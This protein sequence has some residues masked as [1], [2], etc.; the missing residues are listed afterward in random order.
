MTDVF[1]AMQFEQRNTDKAVAKLHENLR[2]DQLRQNYT[3]LDE[4]KLEEEKTSIFETEK[5]Q[6]VEQL[7]TIGNITVAQLELLLAKAGTVCDARVLAVI[8]A[9]L[10]EKRI[11][12]SSLANDAVR[13]LETVDFENPALQDKRLVRRIKVNFPLSIETLRI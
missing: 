10:E 12:I 6:V 9:L 13:V 5:Q 11:A 7:R 3:N 4:L 8:R 2:L 1:K